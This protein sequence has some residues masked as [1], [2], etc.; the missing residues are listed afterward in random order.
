MGDVA[1]WTIS[2]V[3]NDANGA[4]VLAV[5]PYRFP[6]ETT[7][8]DV[9]Q[10]AGGG[11]FRAQPRGRNG[12]FCKGV[13]PVD[14]L[15]DGEPR[16]F[17]APGEGA[18]VTAAAEAPAVPE[19]TAAV[20]GASSSSSS[21]S[22]GGPVL[23]VPVASPLPGQPSAVLDFPGLP[24][25]ARAIL[26][27][28]QAATGYAWAAVERNTDAQRLAS[29]R[30]A[31]VA[32]KSLEETGRAIN[33]G[34]GQ[35]VKV[36]EGALATANARTAT[37]ETENAALRGDRERDR[38][39]LAELRLRVNLNLPPAA[40]QKRGLLEVVEAVVIESVKTLGVPALERALGVSP[41]GLRELEA[42]AGAGSSQ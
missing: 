4:E 28:Q 11:L 8:E 22:S 33:S 6:P 31:D 7:R 36:L 38:A 5:L 42:R 20:H 25:E 10:C 37:L 35:A 21:S 3:L 32:L 9:G 29:E 18:A 15:L 41:G 30:V 19:V 26:Q 39:E 27:A 40:G 17:R 13:K 14:F 34:L 23:S 1:S 24:L 12:R 16:E 2:R